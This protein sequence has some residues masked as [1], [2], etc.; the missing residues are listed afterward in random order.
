[1]KNKKHNYFVIAFIIISFIIG[2]SIGALYFG[3]LLRI[4]DTLPAGAGC[5]QIARYHADLLMRKYDI[6]DGFN[7]DQSNPKR[8]INQKASDLNAKLLEI[9]NTELDR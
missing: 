9:C 1:M 3:V 6:S 2:F 4:D 8:A 5:N 7:T